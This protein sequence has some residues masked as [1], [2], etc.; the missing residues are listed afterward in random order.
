MPIKNLTEVRRLPRLGKIHLGVKKK[1]SKGV[2]YP[3]EVDYFVCPPKVQ[4]VYGEEPKELKI[5]FPVENPEVFF[6]Q[7]YKRYAFNLLKCKGDGENAMTWD[8]E[9]GGMKEI[10]CPCSFLDEGKCKRIGILQFMLPDVPGAGIWQ[11]TTSSWNSIVDINSGIAYIRGLAGRIR[12]I[13]LVLKRVPTTTQRIEDGKPKTGKH[14]TLQIDLDNISARQLQQAGQIKPEESLLSLPAPDESKDDLFYPD[15]GF[16]EEKG[17]SEAFEEAEE[18]ARGKY[19]DELEKE[20]KR[21]HELGGK[22][23]PKYQERIGQLNTAKEYTDAINFLDGQSR[24]LEMEKGDNG[25]PE[26]KT[27]FNGKK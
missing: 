27:L 4:E 3:Q 1:N 10:K 15:N 8:E 2:E 11:V 13:P 21:F 6:Q 12:L 23:P 20:L 18:K 17:D 9:L 5:M 14:Y 7:F 24:A 16:K 22:L 25:N 26:D 19:A